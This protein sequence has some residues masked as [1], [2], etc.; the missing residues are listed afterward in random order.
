MLTFMD[1]ESDG[2]SVI[3]DTSRRAL[4]AARDLTKGLADGELH[5]VHVIPPLRGPLGPG[6]F[7][8]GAEVELLQAIERAS[9]ELGEV[10][11]DAQKGI[12]ARVQ[13]HVRVGDADREIVQLASDIAADLVVVG[14]HGRSG[15]ERVLLGSVAEQ[16]VRRAPC[17]VLT[18]KPKEL[19]AWAKIEPPCPDCV[20]AQRESK[21]ERLWCERHSEHHPRARLHYEYPATYGVGA[22]TFRTP[23]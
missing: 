22:M 4:E 11:A 16:V 7:A 5:V 1:N 10:C 3:L 17:A 21:G 13:G 18:V 6:D 12:P 2:R 15:I 9:K 14:T 19:A 20:K 8:S 23:D